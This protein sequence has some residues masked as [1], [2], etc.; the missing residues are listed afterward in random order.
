MQLKSFPADQFMLMKHQLP[1]FKLKVQE[2]M[3]TLLFGG[4]ITSYAFWNSLF[5]LI[6]DPHKQ[7]G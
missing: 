6:T 3:N 2:N 4:K 7:I 1:S 5:E